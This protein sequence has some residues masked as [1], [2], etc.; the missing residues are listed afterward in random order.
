MINFNYIEIDFVL[1]NTNEISNWIS[2]VITNEDFKEG[3]INYV[4][5]S[6]SY[7]HKLN[8][9]F[10][11]HDTFTD[12]ISFDYSIGEILHGDIFISIDRII[13]NAKQYNTPFNQEL[14]R[15]I[16]HGVLHYCG[17]KDHSEK[18]KVIMRTKEDFYLKTLNL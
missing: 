5:C 7:L 2:K 8:I 15:V 9:E 14:Y 13:E 18:D 12:I 11:S 6:D 10:L 16:I 17:Y 3:D 4:F 1:K